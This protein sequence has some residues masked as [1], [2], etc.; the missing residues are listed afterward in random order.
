MR[1][2]EIWKEQCDAA[3]QIE[4]EFGTEKALDYLIGEKFLNFLEAAETDAEFRAEVPAFVA[5]IKTIFEPWKL[6]EH[7]ETARQSEPFDPSDYEDEDLETASWS[8]NGDQ[9]F[10]VR[11]A[12]GGTGQG[13]VAAKRRA[14]MLPSLLTRGRFL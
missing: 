6:A 7:L 14:L 12:A 9:P 2:C 13:M 8:D 11:L 10:G 1:L 3:R 5:E 4:A